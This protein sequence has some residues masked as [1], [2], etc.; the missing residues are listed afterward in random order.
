MK[1]TLPLMLLPGLWLAA[2]GDYYGTTYRPPYTRTHTESHVYRYTTPPRHYPV[3]PPSYEIN[4][5]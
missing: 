2:C 4:N 1:Y 5:H 3:Q